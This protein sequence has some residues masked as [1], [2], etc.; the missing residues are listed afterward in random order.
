MAHFSPRATRVPPQPPHSL[1]DLGS[2][3]GA[4]SAAEGKKLLA[5]LAWC[6]LWSRAARAAA[7]P[8]EPVALS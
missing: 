2:L 4:S 7:R 8:Q 5:V 6:L 3:V 1:N